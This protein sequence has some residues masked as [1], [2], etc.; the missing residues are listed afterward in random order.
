VIVL[1]P[2]FASPGSALAASAD[3]RYR[4]SRVSVAQ[5][6]GMRGK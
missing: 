1:R 6:T 5:C 4:M 2:I 3:L